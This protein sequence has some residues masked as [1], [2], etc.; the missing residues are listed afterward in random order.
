MSR[1]KGRY[2]KSTVGK[3][4][5]SIADHKTSVSL[6]DAFWQ[7]LKEIAS[8]HD[9]TPL[10]SSLTSTPSGD[11]PIYRRPFA[12]SCSISIASKSLPA[13]AAIAGDD[14][15]NRIRLWPKLTLSFGHVASYPGGEQSDQALAR[16]KRRASPLT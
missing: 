1:L 11:T 5:V 13:S 8:E 14:R 16:R 15:Q 10:N 4:A 7:S 6:E 3:R 12:S 9:M 2:R